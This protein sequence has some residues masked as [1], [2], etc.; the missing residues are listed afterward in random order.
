[1]NKY[2][3]CWE[4]E[5]EFPHAHTRTHTPNSLGD[6]KQCQKFKGLLNILYEYYENYVTR[7]TT[8]QHTKNKTLDDM[9][10]KFCY[11][12]IMQFKYFID[13]TYYVSVKSR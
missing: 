4:C 3:W 8:K 11:P 1:M 2:L 7:T 12:C 9:E 5:I 6:M 10:R 13:V